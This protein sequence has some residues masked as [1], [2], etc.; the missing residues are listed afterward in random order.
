MTQL[1]MPPNDGSRNSVTIFG[2]LYR[3]TPGAP[4]AA[5]DFD[6]PT[7][8]ANGWTV[9]AGAAIPTTT[10]AYESGVVSGVVANP[11]GSPQGLVIRLYIDGSA[12]P[13]IVTVADALGNW[14]APTGSLPPGPHAYSLEIDDSGGTFIVGAAS[15]GGSMDFSS[16]MNSGLLAAIAA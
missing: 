7:L 15:G 1:L 10:S 13:A 12:T 4:I 6:A 14:S 5:P 11:N 2:R 3:S 16:S 8:E 9:F